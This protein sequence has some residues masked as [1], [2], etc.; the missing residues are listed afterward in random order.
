MNSSSMEISF[1]CHCDSHKVIAINFCKKCCVLVDSDWIAARRSFH[2]IWIYC[3]QKSLL[4]R[5]HRIIVLMWTTQIAKFMG[6]TW[7]PPG[8]CR[9]QMGSMLAQWTL[10]SGKPNQTKPQQCT[11]LIHDYRKVYIYIYKSLSKRI[12]SIDSHLKGLSLNKKVWTGSMMT[13]SNGTIF[14]VTGPLW[15]YSP[16]TVNAPHKGHWRGALMFPLIY[17]WTNIWGNNRSASQLRRHRPHHDVTVMS[18]L[19]TA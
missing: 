2:R 4:N 6:P 19:N 17:A 16:V 13:S 12:N 14:H 15:G 9:P 3:Q 1:C 10:L 18:L 11:N 7:G 8:S 5:A